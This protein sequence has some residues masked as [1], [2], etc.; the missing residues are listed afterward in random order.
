MGQEEFVSCR[1]RFGGHFL[2]LF[3]GTSDS[4]L[5]G[6]ALSGFRSS[7]VKTTS[8][9]RRLRCFRSWRARLF[10]KS[11]RQKCMIVN[12]AQTAGKTISRYV[13]IFIKFG[14]NGSASSPSEE[15]IA[16]TVP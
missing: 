13:T 14:K 6:S 9:M 1:R 12:N 10:I 16:L 3:V 5:S 4:L 2:E 8:G 11:R 7:L 15:I